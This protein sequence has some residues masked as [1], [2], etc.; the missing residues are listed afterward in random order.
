MQV[1][2]SFVGGHFTL[3]LVPGAPYPHP[4]AIKAA[5]PILAADNIYKSTAFKKI[6]SI[7]ALNGPLDITAL[8]QTRFRVPGSGYKVALEL[9]AVGRALIAVME[10]YQQP[11]GS[12]TV[13]DVLR[14]YMGGLERIG[15]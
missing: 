8:F 9:M 12:I 14:P 3:T 4:I 7:P 1:V 13:P 11:D 10:T 15:T 5:R 6:G 2:A